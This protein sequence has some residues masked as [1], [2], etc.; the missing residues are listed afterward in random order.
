MLIITEAVQGSIWHTSPDNLLYSIIRLQSNRSHN[1]LP[2]MGP[3]PVSQHLNL[4]AS[5]QHKP[6]LMHWVHKALPS[7]KSAKGFMAGKAMQC[8]HCFTRTSWETLHRGPQKTWTSKTW[9]YIWKVM[10]NIKHLSHK[11]Y[12]LSLIPQLS[13]TFCSCHSICHMKQHTSDSPLHLSGRV[14]CK[15]SHLEKP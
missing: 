13:T 8:P 7:H 5:S 2:P 1:G 12:P 9:S 3:I 6:F 15:N 14:W 4:S 11:L 10:E